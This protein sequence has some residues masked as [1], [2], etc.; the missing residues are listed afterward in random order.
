VEPEI[1]H[2]I[3]R[4]NHEGQRDSFGDPV[5]NHLERV[6]AAVPADARATALLHDLL[7]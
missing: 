1:A 2:R 7:S 6:A 3:A 5:I 4:Q